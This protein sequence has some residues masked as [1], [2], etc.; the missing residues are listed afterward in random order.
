[1][2]VAFVNTYGY[3]KDTQRYAMLAIGNLAIS[4]FTHADIVNSECLT[5]INTCL[6]SSDD[7]TRFNACYTLKKMGISESNLK[8]LGESNVIPKLV[9]VL[10][11][12]NNDAIAQAI[13]ALRHLAMYDE[14]RT[15]IVKAN[16]LQPMSVIAKSVDYEVL[17]EV[18]ACSC[19]LTLG[20]Q[21]RY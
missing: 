21:L 1:M 10:I 3:D 8:F 12:G 14:N 16:A 20:D 17:R 9:D 6:V 4:L 15:L 7:E 5:A 2:D 18:A 19:L 11:S 13:S